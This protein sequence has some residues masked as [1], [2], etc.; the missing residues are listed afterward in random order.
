MTATTT[1]P[2]TGVE[3]YTEGPQEGQSVALY[4]AVTNGQVRNPNGV[5]WPF[6]FG[7][8]HDQP[9]DYYE[10]IDFTSVPYDTELFFVDNESSGWGVHPKRNTEGEFV[11]VPD[12]HPKGEYR[13]TEAIKRRS[14]AELKLIAS[15]Y[16]ESNMSQL[17]PQG[18]G[19]TEWREFAQKE[20]DSGNR[21][22]EV[23]DAIDRHNQLLS[24]TRHNRA[25]LRQ[26]NAEIE[27]AGDKTIT[28]ASATTTTATLSFDAAHGITVGKRIAVKDLPAPFARLNGESFV[29]T[30]VTTSP[31]FTLSYDLIGSSIAT[32]A[33]DV[34]AVT[35]AIDFV[36]G[37]M[38]SEQF[39]EGWVNGIES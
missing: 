27:A 38:A 33:V 17:W 15:R 3:Y 23:V 10:R 34:G 1:S 16:Y 29:V 7:A 24:A 12:G 26:L 8:E 32:A 22:A 25:R 39:P 30:A 9:A 20:Y 36:L 14:V 31:P 4:V 21:S 2:A 6:L 11:A 18:P 37:Q 13:Y 19:Y 5:R 35:P 28:N